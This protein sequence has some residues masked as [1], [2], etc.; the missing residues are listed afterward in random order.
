[1]FSTF[2]YLPIQQ[3]LRPKREACRYSICIFS[4]HKSNSFEERW[5]KHPS[6]AAVPWCN[7]KLFCPFSV[8]RNVGRSNHRSPTLDRFPHAVWLWSF[9]RT[10]MTHVRTVS[11]Y[12]V[13]VSQ[14]TNNHVTIHRWVLLTRSLGNG[15]QITETTDTESVNTRAHLYIIIPKD[16]YSLFLLTK[17][18]PNSWIRE[19]ILLVILSWQNSYIFPGLDCWIA[20]GGV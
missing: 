20:Q 9:L 4:I 7:S 1:M 12:N 5:S 19:Q 15:Y 8:L 2:S 17:S 14:L 6:S 3:L 18:G 13:S 10:I 11:V 16:N